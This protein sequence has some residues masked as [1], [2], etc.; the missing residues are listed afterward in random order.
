MFFGSDYKAVC[1]RSS[2]DWSPFAVDCCILILGSGISTRKVT[3][4]LSLGLRVFALGDVCAAYPRQPG[5]QDPASFS[6]L[7]ASLR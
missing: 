4:D 6:I 7:Q 5:T 2:R 3:W 1:N